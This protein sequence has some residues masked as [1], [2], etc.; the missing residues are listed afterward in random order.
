[1]LGDKKISESDRNCVNSDIENWMARC[2]PCIESKI[3]GGD[4]GKT[5]N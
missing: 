3:D 2:L 4:Y 1:M 5:G